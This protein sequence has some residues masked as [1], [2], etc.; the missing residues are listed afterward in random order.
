MPS[1]DQMNEPAWAWLSDRAKRR[2]TALRGKSPGTS[3][4]ARSAAYVQSLARRAG[5]D[6]EALARRIP[7]DTLRRLKYRMHITVHEDGTRSYEHDLGI[8]EG[9]KSLMATDRGTDGAYEAPRA[10]DES[11]RFIGQ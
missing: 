10:R 5:L 2:V 3:R 11:G 1:K 4:P 6:P 8:V 7:S 9:V